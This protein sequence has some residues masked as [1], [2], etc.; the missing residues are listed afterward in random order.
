MPRPSWLSDVLIVAVLTM[1][2]SVLSIVNI[3][4]LYQTYDQNQKL[5]T[6]NQFLD[7][8]DPTTSCGKKLAEANTE[9]RKWLTDTMQSQAICTL[10][11]ARSVQEVDSLQLEQVYNECVLAR[12]TPQ[13]DPPESPLP[14]EVK[15]DKKT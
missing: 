13:P 14:P 12:A 2:L 9:E 5:Q 10:L 15:K 7:C 8:L 11:T 6:V 3:R 4:I 1:V